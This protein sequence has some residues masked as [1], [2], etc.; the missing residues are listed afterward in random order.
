MKSTWPTYCAKPYCTIGHARET[1]HAPRTEKPHETVRLGNNR[2][3]SNVTANTSAID[4]K[5]TK[6]WNSC[7]P[8]ANPVARTVIDSKTGNAIATIN[9]TPIRGSITNDNSRL[10][11]RG[12]ALGTFRARSSAYASPINKFFPDQISTINAIALV[13]PRLYMYV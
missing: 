2:Y 4:S 3:S 6:K 1:T 13:M 12:R 10:W 7:A 8:S 9:S 11:T 5:Y